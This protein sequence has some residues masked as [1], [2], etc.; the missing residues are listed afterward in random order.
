MSEIITSKDNKRIKN[1]ASYLDGKGECFL[2]EGFHMVEMAI[3]SGL[4][5]NI[6]TLKDY[7]SNVPTYIVNETILKKLTTTK[8]PEGIVALCKKPSKT[9]ELGKKILYLDEVGDPGNVG[10]LLRTALAFGYYDVILGKGSCGVYTPKTLMA[11]QGAIFKL[12]IK[13]S[14]D[15]GINEIN[16]L[17][18][19]G[20][21]I[22]ATDLKASVPP[23]E[24][25]IKEKKFVLVMGNEARGVSRDIVDESDVRVRIEMSEIDSLN[26]G[27]AGGILM[28]LYQ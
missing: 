11:S 1:A 26:V 25:D 27:I 3:E 18:D 24:V 16:K 17:K 22:I 23:K 10:T 9:N 8:N 21:Y 5:L 20:Y 6:F 28:Y 4:A 7:K 13:E 14:K 19:Q 2:V 15:L 12:N